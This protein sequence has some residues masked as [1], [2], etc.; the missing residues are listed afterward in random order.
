L[1]EF[2]CLNFDFFDFLIGY[3][4][5]CR[6]VTRGNFTPPF[7]QN[8]TWKSPFIRLFMLIATQDQPFMIYLLRMY[9]LTIANWLWHGFCVINLPLR[10]SL[11]RK[12]NML[13]PSLHVHY[14]HFCTTTTKSAPCNSTTSYVVCFLSQFNRTLQGSLVPY[15]SLNTCL[16]NCTPDAVYPVI[17]WPVHFVVDISWTVHFWHLC[18]L[19]RGFSVG[20]LAF[21]SA[22]SYMQ[23]SSFPLFL[24]AHHPFP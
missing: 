24:I 1:H 22:Y 23:K 7:P 3:D 13:S 14:K 17:R 5:F 21:N 12:P 4:F 16:A 11:N 10:L 8:R 18:L 15:Y 2:F 9:Q 20:S 6:R 19:L